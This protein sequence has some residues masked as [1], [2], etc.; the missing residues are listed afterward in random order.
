MRLLVIDDEPRIGLTLKLLLEE[1]DVTVTTTG[2][3]ARREV[4]AAS[5]DAVLC[6]LKL[7]DTS[8]VEL[9]EWIVNRRPEMAERVLLMSGG[10][11]TKEARD[12]MRSI[13]RGRWLEKPF[14]AAQIRDALDR[15]A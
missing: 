6:D 5:F 1:H 3:Q 15:I 12:L 8:G 13:P 2:V 10:A 9:T 4:E 7:G 11:M 14:T